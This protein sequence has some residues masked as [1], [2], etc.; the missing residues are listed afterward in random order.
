MFKSFFEFF[1]YFFRFSCD[2]LN[3]FFGGKIPSFFVNVRRKI[4]IYKQA[5]QKNKY[6]INTYLH[7]FHIFCSFLYHPIYSLNLGKSEKQPIRP[8]VSA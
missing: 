2:L 5:E 1:L 3:I 8:L 6:R 4:I 7:P